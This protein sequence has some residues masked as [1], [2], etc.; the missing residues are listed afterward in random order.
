MKLGA[1]VIVGAL[2]CAGVASSQDRPAAVPSRDVDVT[3]RSEQGGQVLEQRSRWAI[4][5]QRMRLD[6]PTPGLYVIVDY[7]TRQMSLVSEADRGVL[8]MP[9][10]PGSIP[11]APD[12]AGGSFVRRGQDQVAGLACTEWESRDT[13]GQPALTCFTG[14]GVLLRARRGPQVLAIATR[15]VYGPMDQSLFTV[16]A[17]YNRVA[18]QP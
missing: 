14:D 13:Q 17:G 3:Y 8:D 10:P 18:K 15:V 6:T 1:A 9:A 4:T 16:P 2:L 7:R 12:P 5:A 11:G